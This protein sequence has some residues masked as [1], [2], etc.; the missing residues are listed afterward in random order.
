[1]YW[2]ICLSV[3][4]GYPH[5][6]IW[7][8]SK[9]KNRNG[10]NNWWILLPHH[11][12]ISSLTLHRGTL[13]SHIFN[14]EW[15]CK[16]IIGGGGGGD[17]GGGGGGGV[18][19]GGGGGQNICCPPLPPLKLFGGV[20]V[21]QCLPHPRT[22]PHILFWALAAPRITSLQYCPI[23]SIKPNNNACFT[24]EVSCHVHFVRHKVFAR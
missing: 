5:P 1:M 2:T 22:H 14:I 8:K 24:Q 3:P 4:N 17:C 16:W 6:K 11:I 21:A 9:I 19:G 18:G 13:W 10:R 20:R 23:H 7:S 12:M 15:K